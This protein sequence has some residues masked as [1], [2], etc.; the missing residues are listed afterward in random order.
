MGEYT[1]GIERINIELSLA[2]KLNRTMKSSNSKTIVSLSLLAR[3]SSMLI[4]SMPSV[5][6]PIRGAG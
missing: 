3:L 1:D 4:R 2:N 5:Y 6:S